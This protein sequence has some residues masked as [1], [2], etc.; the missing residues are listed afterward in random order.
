MAELFD[1]Y[2]SSYGNVVEDSVSFSGLKHDFF[3]RAKIDVL[4]RV[5][6]RTGIATSASQIKALDVG[7]GI[8]AL[9]GFAQSLLPDLSGCDISAESIARAK[10]DNPWVDYRSY[11][12]PVLPYEDGCFDLAFAVCV[13]HHVPPADWIAFTGEMKRVV[14]PGGTVCIIEHNPFNPL[15]KLAVLRCPFDADAVLLGRRKAEKLLA[16]A[17]LQNISAE[18]FLLLPTAAKAARSI[19]RILSGLPIGAQYACFGQVRD[20]QYG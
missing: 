20:D 19:E 4:D 11:Q 5:I 7:C 2:R 17:G 10:N 15:T 9:H 16:A 8:G 18:H 3:L 14:R 13:V 6:S 1:D 12:S